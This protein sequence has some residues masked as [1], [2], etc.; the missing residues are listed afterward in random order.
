MSNKQNTKTVHRTQIIF[1]PWIN[2]HA[3]EMAQART[4]SEKRKVSKGEVIRVAYLESM[5]HLERADFE[6]VDDF[7]FACRK[8]IE[9]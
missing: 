4:K 7:Y 9:G 3:D 1:F 2:K 6:N 5:T 8:I